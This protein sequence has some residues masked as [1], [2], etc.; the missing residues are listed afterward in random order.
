M[1]AYFHLINDSLNQLAI[2]FGST[3]RGSIQ[4][5]DCPESVTATTRERFPSLRNN[6]DPSRSKTTR[7]NPTATRRCILP[8]SF[9]VR[10]Y[11]AAVS[12]H[13]LGTYL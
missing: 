13:N 5:R 4:I 3:E 2:V 9:V 7:S 12:D 8:R 1:G 11:A 6:D 10:S